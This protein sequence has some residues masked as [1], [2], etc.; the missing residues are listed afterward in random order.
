MDNNN[1][2]LDR[3]KSVLKAIPL[4]SKEIVDDTL[5]EKVLSFLDSVIAK[6]NTLQFDSWGILDILKQVHKKI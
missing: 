5:Y 4:M 2:E 1:S 3:A 6:D